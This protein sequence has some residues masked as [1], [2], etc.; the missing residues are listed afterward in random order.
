MAPTLSEIMKLKGDGQEMEKAVIADLLRNSKLLQLAPIKSV[1]G[2]KV[3]GTRWQTLPASGTRALNAAWTPSTG[4]VEQ[5]SETL[6]IYGGEITVDYVATKD[7]TLVEDPLTIQ[8]KMKVESMAYKFSTDF[9]LGDHA[10]DPFGFEGL[11]KRVSNLTSRMTVDLGTSSGTVTLKALAD[12]ASE[13]AFLDGLHQLVHVTGANALL[14]N[15]NTYLKFGAV[16]R[17]LGLLNT[18]QDNFGRK[19]DMFGDA[20]LVDVGLQADQST[21][22]I[23]N[24][25]YADAVGSE[26]FGVRW[27][28]D[29]GLAVIQLDGTSTDPRDP[30][31]GA[32]LQTTPAYMRRID[33]VIGLRNAGRYAIGVMKGFKMAAS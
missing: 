5:T 7:K 14:M 11:R 23:S 22:I 20:K 24:A 16:L 18:T 2:L 12:A 29:D 32:E 27:G 6:H 25:L 10:T 30:T 3:T 19:W 28:G 9:I 4:T 17:R 8:T 13:H 1:P 21:E 33:W 15:E 31:N 26:I